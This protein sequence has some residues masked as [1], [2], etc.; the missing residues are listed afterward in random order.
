M[1][2]VFLTVAILLGTTT[3]AAADIPVGIGGYAGLGIGPGIGVG[4]EGDGVQEVGPAG[5]SGQIFGGI[6][7]KG[8]PI[9]S[10]FG[11]EASAAVGSFVVNQSIAYDSRTLA[12][13]GKYSHPLGGGMDL[14][15]KLGIAHTSAETTSSA[16]T[17]VDGAQGL[18]AVGAEFRI[19]MKV[20]LSVLI[21]YTI[22]LGS[23]ESDRGSLDGNMRFWK[24]GFTIGF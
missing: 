23:L 19:P 15:G 2:R 12:L 1:T 20:Q 5:R 21:D 14:F 18:V 6:R 8:A 24:L 7:F 16:A 9:L 4:F 10:R 17:D 3:V 13:A 22:Y 11:V